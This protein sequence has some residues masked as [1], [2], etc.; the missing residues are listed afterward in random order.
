MGKRLIL[1]G[2]VL[3]LLIPSVFAEKTLE[4]SA[5]MTLSLNNTSGADSYEIGF[6]KNEI[7]A[8]PDVSENFDGAV[9]LSVPAGSFYG[10]TNMVYA[11]WKVM[12]GGHLDMSFDI[13][14]SIV[15]PLANRDGDKLDWTVSWQMDAAAGINSGSISSTEIS[16]TQTVKSFSAANGESIFDAD[17]VRLTVRTETFAG[18]VGEYTGQLSMIIKVTS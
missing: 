6:S 9:L 2:I 7:S 8:F 18:K 10:Y 14:L 5:S 15:N 1:L 4:G 17:S 13:S 3:F 12:K 16:R 11:Y